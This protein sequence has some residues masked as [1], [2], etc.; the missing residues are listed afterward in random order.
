MFKQRADVPTGPKAADLLPPPS[1]RLEGGEYLAAGLQRVSLEQLD[2]AVA[3]L[4][5]LPPDMGIHEARKAM[6]RVRAL[7]RLVR[8]VIGDR[9]YRAE[10]VWLRDSG[11]KI[12]SSR[13]ATVMVQTLDGMTMFY[14]N[15]LRMSLFGEL[16]ERL[17][18]RDQLMR[19][20][21]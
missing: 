14:G 17:L 11:R 20:R 4:E 12:G 21:A 3:A 8:D 9:V 10:N 19:H 1:F 13:D 6:R 15:A 7:L 18:D 2:H 5:R 16:R